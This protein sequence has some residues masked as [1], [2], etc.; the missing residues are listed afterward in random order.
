ML[1]KTAPDQL[2]TP[3]EAITLFSYA[4][5][6]EMYTAESLYNAYRDQIGIDSDG[7]FD[8]LS[9]LVFIYDTGRVQGIREERKRRKTKK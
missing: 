5:I 2:I 6:S 1:E 3:Q 9:L 4:N 8:T 7:I